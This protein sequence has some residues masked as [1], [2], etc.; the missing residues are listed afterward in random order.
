MLK[1][2]HLSS[3]RSYNQLNLDLTE[4]V[5]LIL[6]PNATGKTNI[7]EAVYLAATGH[8]FRADDS[9]LVS[10][11]GDGYRVD[12]TYDDEILSVTFRTAPRK[13]KR[14]L[15]NEVAISQHKLLGMHPVVLFE[16]GD[17]TLL[18]GPPA[19]RR[20]YLDLL[21]SQTSD[22]YY[23]EL[24]MYRRII[25]Q[26]NALLWRNK[27][28]P[29]AN[30]DDQLFILDT[31]LIEPTGVLYEARKALV[32]WLEPIIQRRVDHIAKDSIGISMKYISSSED[33]FE[34][35]QNRRQRDIVLGTTS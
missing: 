18:T 22:S 32:A 20:R 8:S 23:Q 4:R 31:Q 9:A 14:V 35:L 3:F 28:S 30:L 7:L 21:L 5:T 25:K 10:Y 17:L 6:G 11:G 12:T 1:S 33:I 34:Q 29:L 27:R 26:R 16:P 13:Q 15:R 24:V 2:L 19:R